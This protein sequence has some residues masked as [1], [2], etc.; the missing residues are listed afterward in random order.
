MTWT[1][2]SGPVE[3]VSRKSISADRR[4]FF[5]GKHKGVQGRLDKLKASD[6]GLGSA[7]A[8]RS[9]LKRL[10]RQLAGTGGALA[11]KAEFGEGGRFIKTRFHFG[12]AFS[13]PWACATYSALRLRQL[14]QLGAD[15]DLGLAP[16]LAGLIGNL[17]GCERVSPLTGLGCWFSRI[18]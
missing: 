1:L 11:G 3:T 16:Q 4:Q 14:L 10:F 18:C 9:L 7:A 6:L 13:A 8:A 12:P 5:R 2:T 17:S 15:L